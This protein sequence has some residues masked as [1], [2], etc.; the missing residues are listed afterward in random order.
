LTKKNLDQ[1]A[2]KKQIAHQIKELTSQLNHDGVEET[3]ELE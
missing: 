3:D 1:K 2:E